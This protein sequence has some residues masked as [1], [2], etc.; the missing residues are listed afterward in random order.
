MNK[1]KTH[2]PQGHE[3]SKHQYILKNGGRRCKICH[4]EHNKNRKEMIKCQ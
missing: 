3:Y 2:C 1:Q 4:Y